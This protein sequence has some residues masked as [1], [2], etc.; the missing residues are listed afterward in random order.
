MSHYLITGAAGFIASRVAEMLLEQGHAVTG[1][2]NLNDA[3]DVRVKEYRL[4]KLQALRLIATP[5]V[6]T[7]TDIFWEV[8][9][10]RNS[11]LPSLLE[12]SNFA[13][14]ASAS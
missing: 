13:F 1:V 11:A 3:Y 5:G 6:R 2:D 9:T 14:G 12:G 4:R 7:S 10:S 8:S